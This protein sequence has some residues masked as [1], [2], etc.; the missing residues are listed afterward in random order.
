MDT[1]FQTDTFQPNTFQIV[2]AWLHENIS[3]YAHILVR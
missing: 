2:M 3:Y 1:A